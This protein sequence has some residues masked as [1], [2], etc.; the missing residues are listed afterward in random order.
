MQNIRTSN[1][2]VA[3]LALLF[4]LS[5]VLAQAPQAIPYQAAARN[6]A[7]VIITNK[8]I[9]LRFSVH[10]ATTTG[11]VVYK[12]TQNATTN[13]LG[14]F[15]VN[16][17]QGTAVTG[18]FIGINWGSGAKFMQVELDTTAT[19]SSYTDMGTLQLMSVPY[20]LNAAKA[21]NGNPVGTVLSYVSTTAPNGYLVCDVSAINRT[22]YAALF[23]LI[24]TTY[25]NGNGSTTFNL[26]DYRG[27][28]LRGWDN[29]AGN[30]ADASSRTAYLNGTNTGNT[31]GS[32]QAD[33]LK[34][35]N[36]AMIPDIAGTYFSFIV[37]GKGG[38]YG[39]VGN[40]ANSQIQN[41]G[42]TNYVG[43]SETRPKNVY[44]NYIIKY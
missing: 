30:D 16:I 40:N 12:E 10:D 43:G 25:G 7:G 28:F 8:T 44:I 14:M 39:Y 17:G 5:K 15:I 23:A 4:S 2:W 9:G 19:G 11:N 26:P 18:T 1:F 22:T 34:S 41:N 3:I 31:I 6:N 33:T 24:G 21:D 27:I 20:S 38:S 37:V 36:H 29:G 13:A 35:H 42:Q 32:F